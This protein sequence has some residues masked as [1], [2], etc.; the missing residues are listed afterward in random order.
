MKNILEV[1]NRSKNI[2][3]KTQSLFEMQAK[4]HSL[5]YNFWTIPMLLNPDSNSQSGYGSGQKSMRIH[6]DPDLQQL[7]TKIEWG[8]GGVVKNSLDHIMVTTT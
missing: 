2:P 3:T 5:F 1:G 7:C 4:K 6:S 8:G